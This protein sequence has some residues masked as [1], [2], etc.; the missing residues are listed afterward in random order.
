MD[1]GTN[2]IQ[3]EFLNIIFFQQKNLVIFPYVDKEYLRTLELFTDGYTSIDFTEDQMGNPSRILASETYG[4]YAQER[5]FY[6]VS[7]LKKPTLKKVLKENNARVILQTNENVKD[8][9][10][11]SGEYIFYNKKTKKFLNLGLTEKDLEFETQL[12]QNCRNQEMLQDKIHQIKIAGSQIFQELNE[13]NKDINL[14]KILHTIDRRYWDKVFQFVENYYE[15]KIPPEIRK[16]VENYGEDVKQ[17]FPLL[18]FSDE[19][20]Q[21]VSVNHQ[22]GSLFIQHL[23][24]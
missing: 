13:F 10:N 2:F 16:K 18:D 3:P 9:A 7:G 23:H 11:G 20:E 8:L 24:K 19:Y 17:D 4:P 1:S 5:N 21:I 6:I 22:L 14:E 12:I 15:I